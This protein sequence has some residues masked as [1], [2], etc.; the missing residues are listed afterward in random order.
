MSLRNI[1]PYFRVRF[2]ALGYEEWPDAFNRDNIPSTIINKSFHILTPNILGGTINQNH[3][4]TSTTVSIQFVIKGYKEPTEAK[5]KAMWEIEKIVKSVCKIAN[6]TSTLLN[7]VFQGAVM[8]PLN[9]TDDN[10]VLV[11]ME[12]TAEVVLGPEEA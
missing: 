11:D 12:F 2:K 8:N 9:S 3:Q 6:R 4:N 7:V 1:Y 10:Q 5:E